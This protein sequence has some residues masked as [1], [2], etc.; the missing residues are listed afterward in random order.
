MWNEMNFII[1]MHYYVIIIEDIT[2]E[3]LKQ[4]QSQNYM[5]VKLLIDQMK[6]YN[7][8]IYV[9]NKKIQ[10]L[11]FKRSITKFITPM[12]F[13]TLYLN[14][15]NEYFNIAIFYYFIEFNKKIQCSYENNK[16][17]KLNNEMK[18]DG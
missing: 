18:V 14:F 15:W 12:I 3:M 6:I 16:W 8:W 13:K 7:I 1:K 9:P 4:I 5:H 2:F 10:K 17:I 11:W